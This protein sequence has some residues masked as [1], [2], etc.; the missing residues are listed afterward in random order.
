MIDETNIPSK[1]NPIKNLSDSIKIYEE[2]DGTEKRWVY[3]TRQEENKWRIHETNSG[4]LGLKMFG[5]EDNEWWIDIQDE[6]LLQ[7]FSVITEYSF[8][9]QTKN[10]SMTLSSLKTIL[11]S[12]GISFDGG[13]W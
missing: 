12:K 9:R 8:S 1:H 2:T 3:L 4:P 6:N 13:T 7:F 5:K 11:T 10:E